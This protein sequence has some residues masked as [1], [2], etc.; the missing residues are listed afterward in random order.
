MTAIERFTTRSGVKI[1]YLD[2]APADPAGLPILFSP[3]VT[4]FADEY[5]ALLEYF[6]PRRVLVV[7]VRGRGGSEAPPTGYAVTD[8][9]RDL[10]AV[11]EEE[12]ID[13]LHL[14][15]FSRGTSWALDLALSNPARVA[16]FSIGDYR[17][18]EVGMP[19]TFADHMM[20]TTFR[21]KPLTERIPRHV[22]EELQ[23][24]SRARELWD[25][26]PELGPLLVA[27]GGEGS[28]VSD[29]VVEQY[30]AV[31]PDVEIVDI[32][33]AG[34]DLFRPDRTA[35]PAAVADFLARRTPGS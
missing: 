3:G 32:P 23:R 14:M 25:R 16:S 19:D 22:L 11:I 24:A 7:E 31:R 28:M 13:R 29:D 34:H 6:L 12:G 26:L 27:R 8:H 5:G 9:V 10:E 33:G 21:G 4:D 1:R 30:R 35:Y 17:A 15:T 2:N 20:S 18:V